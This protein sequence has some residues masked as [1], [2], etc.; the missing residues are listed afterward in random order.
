MTC[1]QK[2]PTPKNM[3]EQ[4]PLLKMVDLLKITKSSANP[5]DSQEF[6]QL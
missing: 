6:T 1:N 3:S 5:Q 2:V 4:G